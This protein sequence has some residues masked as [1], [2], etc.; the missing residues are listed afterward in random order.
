[1]SHHSDSLHNTGQQYHTDTACSL[2]RLQHCFKYSYIVRRIL[3]LTQSVSGF[4]GRIS[5]Q[6]FN[7]GIEINTKN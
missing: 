5:E 6:K 3:D 2:W 7:K 1:M 4:E